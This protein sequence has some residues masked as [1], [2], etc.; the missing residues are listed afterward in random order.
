MLFRSADAAGIA[1]ILLAAPTAPDER[2][3]RI[4]DR[5][6]G[7]VYAVSLLGVTGERADVPADLPDTVAR[8]RRVCTLPICVGF[9]V[10]TPDQARAVGAAADGVVVGT[11][12][13]DALKGSLDVNN[14]ATGSTVQAVASLVA[15]IASGVRSARK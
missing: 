6:R 5:A 3:P 13:V 10:A 4:C 9:G 11:A 1:T 14:M 7:F 2:L 15:D 12:L 8:L